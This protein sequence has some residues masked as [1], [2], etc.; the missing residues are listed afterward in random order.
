[1]HEKVDGY[2]VGQHPLVSRL[3]K[4]AFNQCP[5]KPQCEVTWDVSKVLDHIESLGSSD[6]LSLQY[7]TRKLAMILA[8]TRQSRSADLVM[9][10]LQYRRYTPDGL[11]FEESGLAKQTREGKPRAELFFP[12]FPNNPRLCQIQTLRAYEQRTESFPSGGDE[13]QMRLFLAAIRP[14]KPVMS[15]LLH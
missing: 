10:D 14:H 12:A 5:P 11:V 1:M 7:L 15:P 9:L 6:S 2:E 3:M 8:V 4:G 13:E